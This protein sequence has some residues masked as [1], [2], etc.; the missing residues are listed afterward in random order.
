VTT[1]E[2]AVELFVINDAEKRAEQMRRLLSP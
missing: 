2:G 1:H